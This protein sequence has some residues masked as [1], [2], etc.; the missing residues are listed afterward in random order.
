LACVTFVS[1]E[2][3]TVVPSG[4]TR[5]D[6]ASA[7]RPTVEDRSRARGAKPLDKAVFLFHSSNGTNV[8]ITADRAN[9]GRSARSR[10]LIVRWLR[11]SW[12]RVE[13]PVFLQR[14]ADARWRSAPLAPIR[15]TGWWDRSEV[16]AKG[17]HR[18]F[19]RPA[20]SG[21]GRK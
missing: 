20:R 16:R 7:T 12:S 2:A 14:A 19:G 8:A 10:L 18:P 21:A 1:R 11:P 17:R 3:R 9:I 4:A 13:G 5:G 6:H 15:T